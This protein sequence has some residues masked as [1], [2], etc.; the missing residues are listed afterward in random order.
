MFFL[1]IHHVAMFVV[2]TICHVLGIPL[3][4]IHFDVDK[5]FWPIPESNEDLE[6]TTLDLRF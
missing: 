6:A 5:S 4:L 1:Q 3:C 2:E